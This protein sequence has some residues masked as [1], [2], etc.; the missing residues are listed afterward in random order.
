MKATLRAVLRSDSG[1]DLMEYSLL[2]ALLSVV[3]VIALKG[4][5]QIIQSA[6]WMVTFSIK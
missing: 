3:S 1:Q 5:G 4:L 2:G 6:L